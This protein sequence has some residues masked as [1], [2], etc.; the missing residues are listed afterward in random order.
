MKKLL[1]LVLTLSLFVISGCSKSKDPLT[2]SALEGY[3]VNTATYTADA[4]AVDFII[5]FTDEENLAV[6]SYYSG[7]ASKNVYTYT[8]EDS[9][10]DTITI[11]IDDEIKK[12]TEIKFVGENNIE[13]KA[14]SDNETINLTR[15]E[16]EKGKKF[17]E[18]IDQYTES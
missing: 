7:T 12:P 13:Y 17:T 16:N 9:S 5:E 8:V 18:I 1:I 2:A 14:A 3:W 15:I 4:E 6:F 11:L 10:S